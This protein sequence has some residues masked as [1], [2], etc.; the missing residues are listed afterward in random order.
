MGINKVYFCKTIIL[1]YLIRV[2]FKFISIPDIS[3][4]NDSP[5][6]KVA[7]DV[8]NIQTDEN[9]KV[10]WKNVKRDFMYLLNKYQYLIDK[11]ETIL[12]DSPI[13][14]MWYQGIQ[15]AP[16]V[17]KM[18]FQSVFVNREKHPLIL[19][20]KYNLGKYLELPN[21]IFQKLKKRRISYA[22]FSDIVR[23][24]LLTR[25]GGYW[26]DATYYISIPLKKVNTSFVSIK[27]K[28]C[29]LRSHP[30]IKCLFSINYL[31]AGKNSFIANFSFA[32][33]LFYWRKYNRLIN[34][35]ILDYI[36]NLAYT[37]VPKFKKIINEYPKKTCGIFAL[38]KRKNWIFNESYIHC[39]Y[40]KL[41]KSGNIYY[42]KIEH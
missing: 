8:E 36:I 23:I 11:E 5:D 9:K 15:K 13:F 1:L 22:A 35:F 33:L 42:I 10:K 39:P 14:M 31:G 40:N 26:I 16:K 4:I 38:H 28:Y 32:C 17:V 25:H 29:F 24:G 7:K 41:K 21:Y 3:I 34:Y 27:P 20:D 6:V 30:F 19:L 18:C 2:D 37:K 12:E